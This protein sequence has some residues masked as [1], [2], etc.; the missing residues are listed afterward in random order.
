[1]YWH[2]LLKSKIFILQNINNIDHKISY[3][4]KIL[5]FLWFLLLIII[6]NPDLIA[7]PRFWA[8]EG[9][10]Y[11]QY[12]I[13]HSFFES[14]FKTHL[15]YFSL[16][17]NFASILGTL[18]PLKNAPLITTLLALVVQLVALLLV[19]F[20]NCIYWDN[21]TKKLII[22][23]LILTI[24]ETEL[25]LNTINSQ[26]YLA[27]SVV[28][29]LCEPMHEYKVFTRAMVILLL[30]LAFFTEPVSCFLMPLFLLK[31]LQTRNKWDIQVGIV[32]FVCSIIQASICIYLIIHEPSEARFTNFDIGNFIKSYLAD[33]LGIIKVI[34]FNDKKN[35]GLVLLPYVVYLFWKNA[36]SKSGLLMAASFFLVTFLSLASA[37]NMSGSPRYGFVPTFILLV[38]IINEIFHSSTKW[39]KNLATIITLV[40]FTINIIFYQSGI[41]V[42]CKSNC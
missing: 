30:L 25:R 27:L 38:L 5:F 23:I 16:F 12:A 2:T 14:L 7:H 39:S 34:G 21:I 9:A 20:G 11:F 26:F 36:K 1:M 3:T 31:A 24:P 6:K 15:V 41:Q 40:T 19:V 8:E 4:F 22:C 13:H 35:V 37:L 28:I 18:V 17:S 29:L 42:S 10:V 32:A 33:F